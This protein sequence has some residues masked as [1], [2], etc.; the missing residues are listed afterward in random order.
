[1]AGP[2][3]SSGLYPASFGHVYE[4]FHKKRSFDYNKALVAA[5]GI[6]LLMTEEQFDSIPVP[7]TADGREKYS[8]RM[9]RV[10]RQGHVTEAKLC[11]L[12]SGDN[13][14]LTPEERAASQARGVEK[15]LPKKPKGSSACTDVNDAGISA[16]HHILDLS[17]IGIEYMSTIENRKASGMYRQLGVDE[18]AYVSDKS[19]CARVQESGQLHFSSTIRDMLAALEAGMSLTYIGM[20][21]DGTPKRVWFLTPLDDLSALQGLAKDHG[22]TVFT[23]R[24]VNTVVSSRPFPIAMAAFRYNLENS[25]ELLRLQQ[26]KVLF[27][28]EGPVRHPQDFWNDDPS[29][30]PGENHRREQEA[31]DAVRTAVQGVGAIILRKPEDKYKTP[32]FWLGF[33]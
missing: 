8:W 30:I 6:E 3:T 9:V 29:Q 5:R 21:S 16:L 32:D 25:D 2:S 20:E 23:A 11:H 26:A 17:A 27:A 7:K 31:F 19:K 33:G 14:V 13:A 10:S 1:M 18:D 28:R 4:S 22:K 12:L 24:L 15:Q